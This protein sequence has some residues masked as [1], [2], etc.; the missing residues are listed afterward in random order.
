MAGPG[1]RAWELSSVLAAEHRVTLVAIGGALTSHPLVR[2][3][4]GPSLSSAEVES[5]AREHDVA[6][7]QGHALRRYPFLASIPTLALVIDLYDPIL[8]EILCLDHHQPAEQ[9]R[10]FFD[11]QGILIEQIQAGDFFVCASERQRDFWMGMLAAVGRI[12]PR[13]LAADANLRRLIDVVPFGV[14]DS[15]PPEGRPGLLRGGMPGIAA[16]DFLLVWGGG[17]WD[18][19]DPL[20]VIRAIHQLS[21]THPHVKL[22]FPGT[23][24]P[25]PDVVPMRMTAEAMQLSRTLEL[26]GR[27]VFFNEGWVRYEERVGYLQEADLGVTAHFPSVETRYAFRTR[28]L[29]YLWAG[30]PVITTEGDE[31]AE[32]VSALGIGEVVSFGDVDGWA[33]AIAGLAGEQARRDECAVRARQLAEQFRWT[34]VASPLTSFCRE[35]RRAPDRPISIPAPAPVDAAQ[36]EAAVTAVES[37]LDKARRTY[38]EGGAVAVLRGVN[39]VMRRLARAGTR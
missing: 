30:L 29:D 34:R 38:R 5:L 17:L 27:S 32:L 4:D 10:F 23:Q 14:P 18:W 3:L 7:L 1:I 35:P 20:T 26:D 37:Y 16:D 2:V 8:F 19:F 6:L 33:M 11:N 13:T 28:V 24:H 31:M 21:R 22:V 9:E 12:S 36:V 39:R 15:A 25:N